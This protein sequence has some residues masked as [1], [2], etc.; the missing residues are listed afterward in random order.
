MI[1]RRQ[2][3]AAQSTASVIDFISDPSLLRSSFE[4]PSWDRWRAVLRAAFALPMSRR[5]RVLFAE[6]AADRAPPKH[7]VKELVCAAGAAISRGRQ[8]DRINEHLRD[9]PSRSMPPLVDVGQFVARGGRRSGR[10]RRRV[11]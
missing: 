11:G 1:R 9:R 6:V 4:G 2:P 3:Y 8:H 5:D 7:R 10:P